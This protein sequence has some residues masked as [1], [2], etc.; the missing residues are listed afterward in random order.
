MRKR[1]CPECGGDLLYN[2][3]A[4]NYVCIKCG[5]VYD[6][7]ELEAIYEVKKEEQ[8]PKSKRRVAL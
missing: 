3:D 8:T 7:D 1:S 6:R 5:R 4:K 2:R